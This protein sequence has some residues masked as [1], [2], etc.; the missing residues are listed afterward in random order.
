MI[1]YLHEANVIKE[2]LIQIRRDLH[3]HPELDFDLSRTCSKVTSFLKNEKINY[4]I[5]AKTGVCALIKGNNKDRRNYNK[6]IALRADL[7]ALPIQDKK[8]CS[9]KSKEKGK[10]HAC[11]HDAHCAILLGAAKII[12]KYK[13]RFSGNVKLFFE[14]AEETT[15]GSRLMIKENV[16]EDPYVDT[17]VGLHVEETLKT[18]QISL[19]KGIGNASSNPFK[20]II[21]GKGGHGAAP[22]NTIDPI[23]IAAQII[24]ALQIVISR[25]ISPVTKAVISIGSIHSGTASNIIPDNVV[26]TG[27]IRTLSEEDRKF[28][29]DRFKTIIDKITQS[30]RGEAVLR[31][32]EGYPCLYNNSKVVDMV[33]NS[34]K[35][36][37][38]EENVIQKENPSLGVESFAYFAG[39]RP[40][41]FYYL[42]TGNKQ[43]K[44]DYPAHGSLF[45]IDEDAIVIG[46]ALQSK[47]AIDYLTSDNFNINLI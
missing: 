22:Q 18:G 9:Y 1:D 39:I 14:P 31:I 3:E 17:V 23:V 42:G 13:E 37:I 29:L 28:I 47:I 46:A 40:S 44:T 10:M 2:E 19:R 34:A 25:E 5:V 41:T 6:T 20:I 33:S 16:L 32:E 36:L 15:G 30:L 8:K 11:G 27:I 26:I 12:N 4:K 38:G 35:E 43:K 24:N 7:D 21:K 45:D